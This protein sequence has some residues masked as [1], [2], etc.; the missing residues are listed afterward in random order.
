MCPLSEKGRMKNITNIIFCLLTL[1]CLVNA[2]IISPTAKEFV[3]GKVAKFS[4]KGHPKSKG[5]SFTIKYPSSWLAKEGERPNVVQNFVSD[6]GKGFEMVMIITKAIPPN[7]PFTQADVQEMLSLE[8]LK[9][10]IPKGGKFLNAKST[11]IENDPAGIVEY[12]MRYERAGLEIET[13]SLTFMFFQ[14]RTLVSVQ[15]QVASSPAS[16]G[17]L[18]KRYTA[19]RP[20]LVMMMNSIVFNDKWK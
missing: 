10:L 19:L 5:T 4:T 7:E 11:K 12:S 6:N 1:T 3:D 15:F 18:A 20:L 14:K 16:S 8:G 9:Q 2:Q 17:D 13:Q